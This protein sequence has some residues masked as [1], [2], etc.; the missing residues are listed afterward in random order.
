MYFGEVL[1]KRP[2]E[3]YITINLATNDFFSFDFSK[4][5][6]WSLTIW[7][8]I[9]FASTSTTFCFQ[10]LQYGRCHQLLSNYNISSTDDVL[11]KEH[12]PYLYF[13]EADCFWLSIW[14]HV[15]YISGIWLKHSIIAPL[16]CQ[17][18]SFCP[19]YTL[20][21]TIK[22]GVI[23]GVHL[24]PTVPILFCG[25]YAITNFPATIFFIALY[26]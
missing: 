8:R 2:E 7:L 9:V 20:A 23:F 18:F 6:S 5:K 11:I 21:L 24:L 17:N 13:I 16:C 15:S 14:N 25:I 3:L 10:E 22:A 26:P 19:D 4:S 1:M 12:I